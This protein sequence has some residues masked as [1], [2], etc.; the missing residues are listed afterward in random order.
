MYRPESRDRRPRVNPAWLPLAVNNHATSQVL[1]LR[2]PQVLLAALSSRSLG[3]K[4]GALETIFELAFGI[5]YVDIV[6]PLVL[7]TK[8][9]SIPGIPK[10]GVSNTSSLLAHEVQDT[11]VRL[12]VVMLQTV[13]HSRHVINEAGPLWAPMDMT[14]FPGSDNI[15]LDLV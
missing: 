6:F 15:S 14:R 1:R 2:L 3:G 11:L 7:E 8:Q 4:R 12:R 9:R 5:D 10:S 13:L